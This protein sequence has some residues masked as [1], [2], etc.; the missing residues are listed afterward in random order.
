LPLGLAFILPI[1]TV[2]FTWAP[3]KPQSEISRPHPFCAFA[4]DRRP[5]C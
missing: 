2:G 5:S 1:L 3:V 4:D